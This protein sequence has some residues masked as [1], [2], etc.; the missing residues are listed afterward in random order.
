MMDGVS[1][2]TWASG[3]YRALGWF[4]GD[5]QQ[6]KGGGCACERIVRLESKTWIGS[7]YQGWVSRAS[8]FNIDTSSCL[9]GNNLSLSS[10]TDGAV[11]GCLCGCVILLCLQDQAL[12]LVCVMQE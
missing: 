6:R 4:G 3:R 5:A 1:M 8:R 7:L 10:P 11:I 2:R 9:V 12:S